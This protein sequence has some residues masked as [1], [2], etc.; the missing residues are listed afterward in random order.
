M[1]PL[2]DRWAGLPVLRRSPIP[3]GLVL[4]A[5]LVV[6]AVATLVTVELIAGDVLR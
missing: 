3:V 2:V 6:Q 1:G 5:L 4:V